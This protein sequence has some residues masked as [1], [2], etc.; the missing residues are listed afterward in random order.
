MIAKYIVISNIISVVSD[1]ILRICL[2]EPLLI[3]KR[4]I[5]LHNLSAYNS[6]LVRYNVYLS[7]LRECLCTQAK[8]YENFNI[9]PAS[10]GKIPIK[11]QL[12]KP[13]CQPLLHCNKSVTAKVCLV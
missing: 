12:V 11:I 6:L 9:D 10:C 8:A 5:V 3:L 4:I 13:N 7:D 2:Q 1:S